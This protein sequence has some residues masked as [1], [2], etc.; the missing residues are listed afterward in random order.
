MPR[1]PGPVHRHILFRYG[2]F[3]FSATAQLAVTGVA[4]GA[5]TLS[6]LK[7]RLRR[8][9]F[10]GILSAI[11]Y[12][13]VL[14]AM[15][16]APAALVAAVRE[17]SILFAALIGWGLLGEKITRLRWFGVILTVIGLVATRL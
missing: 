8:G 11:A 7:P 6:L 12:S 3:V 9:F 14:W 15:T 5:S 4:H 17:T 1:A 16:I 10:V 13:V 2:F